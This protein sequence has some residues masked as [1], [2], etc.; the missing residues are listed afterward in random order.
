MVAADPRLRDEEDSRPIQV[1]PAAEPLDDRHTAGVA[2]ADSESASAP[3]L[4]SQ[5]R[6]QVNSQHGTG[7]V[8]IPRQDITKTVGQAQHPLANRHA[9][10][11][12]IDEASGGL[13]HAAAAAAGAEAAAFARERHEPFE[14]ALAAPETAKAVR[15]HAA[16]EEMP[17]FLFH[18]LRQAPTVGVLGHRIQESLQMFFDY[19]AVELAAFGVARLMPGASEEH[20]GEVGPARRCRQCR[21]R[22]TSKELV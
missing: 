16:R 6:A 19:H 1:E 12:I 9:R 5:E 17:E 15:Q 10:Q 8:V 21:K 2:I 7:E 13:G 11:H 18:E 20:A 22:D 3:A 4:E 14:R